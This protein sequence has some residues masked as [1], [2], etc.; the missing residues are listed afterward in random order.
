M[1]E[2][3]EQIQYNRYCHT[4]KKKEKKNQQKKFHFLA[5]IPTKKKQHNVFDAFHE[6]KKEN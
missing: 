3:I 6:F 1:N 5:Q 2:Y 4:K